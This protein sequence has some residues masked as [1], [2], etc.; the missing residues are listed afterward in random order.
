MMPNAP[1][2]VVIDDDK[3]H[4]DGL[5]NALAR[6]GTPCHRIHYTGESDA[7]PSCPDVR[8][9]IAD[10]HLGSGVLGAD[11]TTDFS[12]LGALLEEVIRPSGP[13]AILLWTKYPD[14]ATELQEFLGRLRRVPKPVVVTA[15]PK[16][17][18][19]DGDGHVRDEDA[20]NG[21][22]H[23]QADGWI[24]PRGALALLGRWGE[25][26]DEEMDAFVE[27]VY[28]ARGHDL[29]RCEERKD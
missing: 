23:E 14:F 27:E 5:A 8:F 4:L 12:V 22:I 3:S 18:H 9:V 24:H 29:D 20:L 17:D 19:L 25:L 10:L 26:E 1:R 21:Q 13:Y 15:L 16:A 28:A 7:I 6:H 11:P 2:I